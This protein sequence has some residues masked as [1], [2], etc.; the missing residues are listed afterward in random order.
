MNFYINKVATLAKDIKSEMC[1]I[2]GRNLSQYA[3]PDHVLA[4]AY[5]LGNFQSQVSTNFTN[6]ERY[7]PFLH[8]TYLPRVSS[9][10]RTWE[11]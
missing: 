8:D 1:Q 10:A 4:L 3:P 6:L 2:S 9:R 11:Y 7:Q 5:C